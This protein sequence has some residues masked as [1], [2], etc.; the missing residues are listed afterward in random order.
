MDMVMVT[1]PKNELHTIPRVEE[2]WEELKAGGK[3][4][5]GIS[6]AAPTLLLAHKDQTVQL[7]GGFQS[8]SEA[9]ENSS[10]SPSLSA[11]HHRS[12]LVQGRI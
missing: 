7:C 3:G 6:E 5:G 8:I 4:Q 2:S 10:H 1:V 11:W 9:L 12:D